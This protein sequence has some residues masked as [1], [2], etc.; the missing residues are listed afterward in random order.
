[1][2]DEFDF[3]LLKDLLLATP[4]GPILPVSAFREEKMEGFE[5]H[6][7][8]LIQNSLIESSYFHFSYCNG[9]QEA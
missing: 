2:N 5:F 7:A 6:N 3:L 4:L 8:I 1:M 9:G